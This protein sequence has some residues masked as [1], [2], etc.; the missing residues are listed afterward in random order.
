LALL[1]AFTSGVN[2]TQ[3]A[4]ARGTNKKRV[5]VMVQHMKIVCLA[6]GLLVTLSGLSSVASAIRNHEIS[7]SK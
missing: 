1:A 2:T 3:L 4:F 7:F 5:G 6:V